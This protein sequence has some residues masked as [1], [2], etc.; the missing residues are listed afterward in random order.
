MLMRSFNSSRNRSCD[1]LAHTNIEGSKH[2]KRYEDVMELLNA[3][4][5][6]VRR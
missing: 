2:R 4:I 1:E 5:D 3:Q 6:V